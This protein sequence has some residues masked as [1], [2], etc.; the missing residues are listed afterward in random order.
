MD[1]VLIT[2]ASRGIGLEFARQYAADGWQVYA[3]CRN[4]EGAADLKT[5]ATAPGVKLSVHKMDT[6][7]QASIQAVADEL[8]G[9]EI[10]ILINNAGISGRRDVGVG[11]LDYDSW[12]EVMETN[13]LAPMK[14]TE[15]FLEH[16]SESYMQL[17][18]MISSRMGSIGDTT[19]GGS[20][21]Y[22]TS[23]SA[24][25]MAMR[26]LALET[27]SNGL[28]TVSVHPGWVRTDMG[29]TEA[30]LT[31]HESVSALRDLFF[32]LRIGDSGKFYNYDGTEL[33]W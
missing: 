31:T 32:Q 18:V 6:T 30:T 3:C 17:V 15:A 13:V 4:P 7:D 9:E 12:A 8:A 22:R 26:C 1:S 2:G 28:T 33:P 5:L 19:S 29:G 20:M 16:V 10:D 25:N 27:K 14:V 21:I 24:L 11:S 23:K